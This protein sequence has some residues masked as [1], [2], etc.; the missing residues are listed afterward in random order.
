VDALTRHKGMTNAE[1]EARAD[2]LTATRALTPKGVRLAVRFSRPVLAGLCVPYH[3]NSLY[4]SGKLEDAG[5]P[6]TVQSLVHSDISY[7]KSL[8][9]EVYRASGVEM[10]PEIDWMMTYQTGLSRE[11]AMQQIADG[12][13]GYEGLRGFAEKYPIV[14]VKGAAESGARNLRVF[15][16]G[17][18]KN[19]WDE[20]ELEAAALF[21]YERAGK[22][23][24]V[25]QEAARTTPEFWASPYYMTN[26]VNRQITEWHAA[27]NRDRHPRSQIYGSLRIIASSSHPDRPYDLTHLITLASLQV[28]TNVGRGGTLEPLLDH[29]MSST[30]NPFVKVFPVR[31][32]SS[33][34][35]FRATRRSL[36]NRSR[37]STREK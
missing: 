3:G 17:R 20:A 29:F 1:A 21:I 32:R 18:G 24:M 27:V 4:V 2:A 8:Y 31:S 35:R 14:L 11:Q 22:Q 5:L 16:I 25:I 12:R 30:L 10:P 26:F 28:A 9:P 37:P 33:C 23:N 19:S 15:Q 7:D 6:Y 34:R 13:E 36:L